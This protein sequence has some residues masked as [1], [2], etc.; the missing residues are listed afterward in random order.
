MPE[1][2]ITIDKIVIINKIV[3]PSVVWWIYVNADFDTIEKALSSRKMAEKGAKSG[4]PWSIAD[5]R[6]P[7]LLYGI[8]G[9]AVSAGGQLTLQKR[10]RRNN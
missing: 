1:G 2:I 9:A 10:Q 3:L 6:N 8:V 4:L 7:V 5:C